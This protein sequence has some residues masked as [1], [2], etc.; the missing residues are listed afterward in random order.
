MSGRDETKEYKIMM[1][2]R[3][4]ILIE[5]VQN[6][7]TFDEEEIIMDTRMGVLVL[8]GQNLHV[9]QLNLEEEVLIADGLCKSIEFSED[10]KGIKGKGMGFIQRIL[11]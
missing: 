8:K 1:T 10:R 3:R 7:E 5:G 11:K 2:N 4:N 9:V 6:V